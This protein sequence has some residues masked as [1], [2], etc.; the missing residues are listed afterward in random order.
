[1]Y[2]KV[3]LTKKFYVDKNY[4]GKLDIDHFIPISKF[5]LSDEF[6]QRQSCNW[7]NLRYLS[8]KDNLY[9]GNK[10]PSAIEKF[11]YYVLVA[12]FKSKYL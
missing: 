10:I 12:Y 5:N 7:S 1:M 4:N 6:E 11:R 2:R 9:K 3:N 8:S